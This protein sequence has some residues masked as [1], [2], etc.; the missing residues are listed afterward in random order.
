MSKTNEA[1]NLQEAKDLL[2]QVMKM[3]DPQRDRETLEAYVRTIEEVQKA[4]IRVIAEMLTCLDFCRKML[5]VFID[6]KHRDELPKGVKSEELIQATKEFHAR[7]SLT[8]EDAKKIFGDPP[9]W[10]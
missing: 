3:A 10:S 5:A 8:I 1:P 7:I 9:R 2:R 4:R 6:P